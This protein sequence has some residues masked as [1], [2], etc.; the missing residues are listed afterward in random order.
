MVEVAEVVVVEAAAEVA[1]GSEQ[2][3]R[4]RRS[5]DH[6][7]LLSACLTAA[8]VCAFITRGTLVWWVLIAVQLRIQLDHRFLFLTVHSLAASLSA[9]KRC[10]SSPSVVSRTQQPPVHH[11]CTL[12]VAP[13]SPAH[14]LRFLLL[15]PSSRLSHRPLCLDPFQPQRPAEVRRDSLHLRPRLPPL[16]ARRLVPPHVVRSHEGAAAVLTAEWPLCAVQA[17][18]TAQPAH[19]REAQ[20]AQRAGVTSSRLR[21]TL[22]RSHQLR[23]RVEGGHRHI[24]RHRGGRRGGGRGEEGR[25]IGGGGDAA[26]IDRAGQRG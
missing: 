20:G 13:L 8:V 14:L 1:T 12:A 26:L 19:R 11:Q 17:H 2:Q 4:A 25:R 7:R 3:P 23:Q 5:A 9:V 15:P 22:R 16:P 21:P 18:V 6:H 10:P 24:R